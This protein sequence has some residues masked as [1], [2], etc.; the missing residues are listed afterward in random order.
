VSEDDAANAAIWKSDEEVAAWL[1]GSGE[2]ERRRGEQ[3]RLMAD[4]LPFDEEDPFVFVDLGAGTGAAASA[5]LERY[6]AA[7][8]L[9]AEYSP[10]MAEAGGRALE[11][12]RGRYR[13]VD[14]DLA[15]GPWPAAMPARVDAVISS[16]CL[17]HLPDRRK[18]QLC[19]EVHARLAPGGGCLALDLVAGDDVAVEAAWRRVDARRGP[20]AALLHPHH[21]EAERRHHDRAV[22][23]CP[24]SLRLGFLRAAGFEGVDAFWKLL[25][26]VLIGGRRPA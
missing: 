11:P 3:R 26:S 23:L 14:F 19:A 25:D 2:R 4:L 21:T 12:Y 10:Q 1:S 13:Y 9:L 7:T 22:F 17:H 5:V 20:D 18:E 6:P 15:G 24:L 16:M 8:A